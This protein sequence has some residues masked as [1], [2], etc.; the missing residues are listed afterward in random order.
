[1]LQVFENGGNITFV[2][3]KCDWNIL[4]PLGEKKLTVYLNLNINTSVLLP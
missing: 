3:N 1:M 4:F 2:F